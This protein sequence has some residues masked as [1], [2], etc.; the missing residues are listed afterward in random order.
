MTSQLHLCKAL[1][2]RARFAPSVAG[3][4]FDMADEA[5]RMG[6]E[7]HAACKAVVMVNGSSGPEAYKYILAHSGW[8]RLVLTKLQTDPR[9]R[10]EAHHYCRSHPD[11]GLISKDGDS[12]TI[13]IQPTR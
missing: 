10:K 9:C 1:I 11:N 4:P 8:H 13:L 3:I 5:L 2:D 12:Y 7:W 6:L